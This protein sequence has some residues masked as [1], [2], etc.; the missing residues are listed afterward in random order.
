MTLIAVPLAWLF[1]PDSPQQARFLHADER[2]IV[3]ARAV[4]Q[5]GVVERLGGLSL[6]EFGMTL[7]DFKAWFNAVRAYISPWAVAVS[8]FRPFG[9][10]ERQN[11]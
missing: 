5:V 7:I 1:I 10:V 2:Q 8:P 4:R 11:R 6:K 9:M 3:K